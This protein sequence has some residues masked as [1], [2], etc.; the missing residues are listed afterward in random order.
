[1]NK[2]NNDIDIEIDFIIN[3]LVEHIEYEKFKGFDPYDLLNSSYNLN[4]LPHFL[5]FFLSQIN[6][7]SFLNLRKI[8]KISPN[9]HT[10][11][12]GLLLSAYCNLYKMTKEERHLN[13]CDIIFRWLIEKRKTYN[14]NLC[15]GFD[16][17]YVNRYGKIEN[18]FPTIIHHS[19]IVE[20]LEKYYQLTGSK[21]AKE[22]IL[23]SDSFIINQLPINNYDD[24]ICFGY[25]P[26]ANGCCYNASMHAA[27]TLALIN[28]Y[29][30]NQ[31]YLVL[32]EKA[33]NFIISKQKENGV[34]FY[35][36]INDSLKEKKQIDFHQGFIIE[37]LLK[38][39]DYTSKEYS[40]FIIPSV[41]KGLEFYSNYQ[42]DDFGRSYYRYPQKYPID[43]HNQAQGIITF[44][45]ASSSNKKYLDLAQKILA[46]TIENMFDE[47]GFFYYQK[48]PLATN[49]IPYIRWGQAWMLFAISEYLTISE[50]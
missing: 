27:A 37:S 16:Y 48:Y 7:N 40:D 5:Q 36:F 42:F 8:L 9:Y 34:W 25:Y 1:L 24:G 6:K 15:W 23:L 41:E 21:E 38:I 29:K 30:V 10:K 19:Y 47:K 50:Q 35:S 33:V 12:M 18:G 17:S 32:V 31:N 13:T 46:W 11:G 28:K 26:G 22:V 45:K 49:K 3:K 43:I 14:G 20:A 2:K 44:A 4:I 39:N